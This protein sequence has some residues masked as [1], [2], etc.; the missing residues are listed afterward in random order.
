MAL[1]TKIFSTG[2]YAW[3]SWSNG[4]VL[5]LSL[6]QES[7][8]TEQN[9]SLVSYLLTISNTD[10]NRFYSNDYSWTISIGG[11]S[12][13]I[14][15]FNFDLSENFTTQTIASG[16]VTVTHREDGTMDMPYS[17]SVPN[18]QAY[19]SYGPPAMSLSGTWS[20][21]AIA[22][23]AV[24]LTAKD[25][26]DEENP[27]I[28]YS[29]TAGSAVESLQACISLDGSQDHIA[30]RDISPTGSTYTFVLTAAERNVL[31]NAIPRANSCNVVFQIKTVI[32]GVTY[33]HALADRV[34]TIVNVNP[35]FS[36]EITDVN[37]ATA[38]L[39]G[40]VNTFV[41]YCSDAYVVPNC[42]A[43]KGASITSYRVVNGSKTVSNAAGTFQALESG[44]FVFC[45]ED[46]RGNQTKY[47]VNKTLIPYV[48]LTAD[49]SA[50]IDTDGLCSVQIGGNY[51]NGS[52][53]AVSN[54]LQVGWE[55][56]EKGSTAWSERRT[57]TPEAEG[58]TYRASDSVTGLDYTKTY[59]LRAAVFDR[60]NPDGVLSAVTAVRSLPV[61]DWSETDFRFHVPVH[62]ITADMIGVRRFWHDM[63]ITED[64]DT[65]ENCEFYGKVTIGKATVD[66]S[67]KHI[68]VEGGNSVRIINCTFYD[69]VTI[70]APKV[71]L[72]NVY[73]GGKDNDNYISG[74]CLVLNELA[75]DVIISEATIARTR[76]IGIYY[77]TYGGTISN[78]SIFRCDQ[79][80]IRVCSGGAQINNG[81]IFYCGRHLNTAQAD[82]WCGGFLAHAP[83]GFM[84]HIP[85]L[86]IQNVSIQQNFGFGMRL[87]KVI[88]SYLDVNLIANCSDIMTNM[89]D[90]G[91]YQELAYYTRE[92]RE[93]GLKL[94]DCKN[95]SGKVNGV[96]CHTT[97]RGGDRG[98]YDDIPSKNNIDVTWEPVFYDSGWNQRKFIRYA[99][100]LPEVHSE[101]IGGLRMGSQYTEANF[102]TSPSA[103]NVLDISVIPNVQASGLVDKSTSGKRRILIGKAA[104]LP[105]KGVFRVYVEAEGLN[106]YP[107]VQIYDSASGA[108]VFQDS[109]DD[110][111][112]RGLNS[113]YSGI[114]TYDVGNL[115]MSVSRAFYL[116]FSFNK[117]DDS[118]ASGTVRVKVRVQFYPY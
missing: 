115:D 38:A 52:F 11:K 62:G 21:K 54:T 89:D 33:V 3:H 1:Q 7:V 60:V 110:T 98:Y 25:F 102:H 72:K 116:N 26:T 20:L 12:I 29:N 14:S 74:H 69:T 71:Q 101:V 50:V 108:T 49:I 114:V 24:L 93:Y 75:V 78:F 68:A 34:F 79:Y 19:V 41:Q 76:K 117:V 118:V 15:H 48:K 113:V 97:W 18:V 42:S 90:N 23:K 77:H 61:F 66:D 99:K 22:R 46:S 88:Y 111:T 80:G 107:W 43:Q 27:V 13:A 5:S 91:V 73:I 65:F 4:Y 58:N 37:S 17:V 10:N 84:P 9:T 57:V 2:D 31:Y 51:F 94:I 59:E 55:Y 56:R 106:I 64:F 67:G 81:K 96:S 100:F 6:T 39:T 103:S 92:T 16:Q 45:A 83:S 47:T 95:I 28:T 85:A 53:G 105:S 104:G 82:G 70:N 109:D 40:D 44:K 87:N 32:G 63:T 8:N 30:Y 86:C 36:P 35:V 112:A